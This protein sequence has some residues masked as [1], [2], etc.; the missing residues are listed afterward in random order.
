[1]RLREATATPQT[2][3][4]LTELVNA[5]IESS[6]RGQGA[7]AEVLQREIERLEHQARNLLDWVAKGKAQGNDQESNLVR[8]E[9]RRLDGELGRR[10]IVL[11][12]L[13]AAR[14]AMPVKAHPGRI[15]ERLIH[16]D[17]LLA[18]DPSRARVE[19]LKHLDGAGRLRPLPAPAG[20]RAAEIIWR[21]KPN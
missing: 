19:I 4:R 3:E 11:A 18:S 21:V 8:E 6:M 2:I 7:Q 15:R 16:L 12:V 13:L 1:A 9:L 20:Q 17:Q 14:Q 5:R 10:R